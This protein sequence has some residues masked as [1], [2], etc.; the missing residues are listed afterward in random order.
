M[1]Q[2]YSQTEK[3]EALAVFYGR[4][5]FCIYLVGAELELDINHKPLE[6]INN[7]PSKLPDRIESW[8]LRRQQY[9]FKP[10]KTNPTDVLQRQPLKRS[11]EKILAKFILTVFATNA[12]LK[13]PAKSEI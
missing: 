7:P 6:V 13:P 5:K 11:P 9:Q 3:K 1:E 12:V 2:R 4:E 8:T 10:T